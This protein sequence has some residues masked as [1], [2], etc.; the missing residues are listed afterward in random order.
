MAAALLQ[1]RFEQRLYGPLLNAQRRRSAARNN[2]DGTYTYVY[3]LFTAA[4]DT[5]HTGDFNGDGKTDVIVYNSK[6]ALAYIGLGSGD[7]TFNFQSLFRSP[8]Y[9]IVETGDINADG[10][11]RRHAV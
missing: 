2:G 5:L 6:T 7:G 10:K 3:N 11:D 4:F 9:H 1:T 8:A